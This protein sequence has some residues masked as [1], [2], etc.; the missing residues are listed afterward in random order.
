MGT[1]NSVGPVRPSAGLQVEPAVSA[2]PHF[3][4]PLTV[5]IKTTQEALQVEEH[6][7]KDQSHQHLTDKETSKTSVSSM[8]SPVKPTIIQ[9]Q[10][11]QQRLQ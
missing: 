3:T 10:A 8:K 11:T 5:S 4:A 6:L 2:P 7:Q 9:V 1:L